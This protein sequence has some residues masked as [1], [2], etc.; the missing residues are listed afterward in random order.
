MAF[1]LKNH[2]KEHFEALQRNFPVVLNS[3][4][5]YFRQTYIKGK[6]NRRLGQARPQVRPPRYP[7]ALW[8][9]Y[10]TVRL[11]IARTNNQ[12]KGQH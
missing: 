9:Q 5:E 1:V 8:N 6:A 12:F 11:G 10:D 4:V 2:I 7:P 3:I